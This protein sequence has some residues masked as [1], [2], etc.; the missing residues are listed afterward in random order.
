M[1]EQAGPE[2]PCGKWVE[3]D[4]AH[5]HITFHALA[6]LIERIKD[7]NDKFDSWTDVPTPRNFGSFHRYAPVVPY[8]RWI[9]I[10]KKIC[11]IEDGHRLMHM[12]MHSRIGCHLS[13]PSFVWT[14][15]VLELSGLEL[16]FHPDPPS[17]FETSFYP[18]S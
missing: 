10:D 13:S 5:E 17:I 11:A 9:H 2:W 4:K 3:V 16:T 18:T 14:A 8:I 6:W 15:R 12:N 7:I 1:K